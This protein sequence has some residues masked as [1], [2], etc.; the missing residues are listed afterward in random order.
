MN[1]RTLEDLF[2]LKARIEGDIR[3]SRMQDL[4]GLSRNSPLMKNYEQVQS[5]IANWKLPEAPVAESV[6]LDEKKIV[7][8]SIEHMTHALHGHHTG[9]SGTPAYSTGGYD[10]SDYHFHHMGSALVDKHSDS[11]DQPSTHSKYLVVHK[12]S[13]DGSG[14]KEAHQFTI[15]YSP[16]KMNKELNRIS[17]ASSGYDVKH[18]AKVV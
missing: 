9:S 4:D 16:P 1:D 2:D 3:R 17:P 18:V 12:H 10:H 7:V 14:N 15:G 6:K 11:A 13:Y 5:D 8:G